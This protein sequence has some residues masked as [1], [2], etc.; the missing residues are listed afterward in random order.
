MSFSAEL[1]D[2]TSGFKSGAD[3]YVKLKDAKSLNEYRQGRINA[4]AGRNADNT[5]RP[6]WGGADGGAGNGALDQLMNNIGT[7]ESRN[8]YSAVGKPARDGSRAYGK[9]QVTE[10]NIGPW[11]HQVLG[12]TMGVQEFLQ[13]H[14]AQEKVARAKM[15]EYY[16]AY[17]NV[18]DVASAW[19]TGK[20]LNQTSLG[21]SDGYTNLGD[22]LR[23]ATQGITPQTGVATGGQGS[24]VGTAAP[25]GSAPDD[26]TNADAYATPAAPLP[27]AR[28]ED[29]SYDND[30][31]DTA[32]A[33]AK[34][35]LVRGYADGGTVKKND[36]W[37]PIGNPGVNY[38]FAPDFKKSIFDVQRRASEA[39]I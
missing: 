25:V 33:A 27:P 36:E 6:G 16:K 32:Q 2:F 21:A 11:T 4:M 17:G 15:G 1:K 28:P 23:K 29:L 26:T 8:D 35:G 24:T 18:N 20:P 10:K 9:Y 34:G 7:L 30:D 14:D 38:D 31:P 13:D 12:K 19:F 3:M 37:T 39:G 22:Y 5:P